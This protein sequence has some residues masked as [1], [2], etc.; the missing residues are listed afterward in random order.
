MTSHDKG[1]RTSKSFS[2]SEEPDSRIL[3]GYYGVKKFGHPGLLYTKP[4]AYTEEDEMPE[5]ERRKSKLPRS[6]A[7]DNPVLS[8]PRS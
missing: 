3:R 2:S 6:T 8:Q 1:P 7:E 5:G 4:K